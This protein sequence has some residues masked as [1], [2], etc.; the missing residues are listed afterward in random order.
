MTRVVA[1]SRL[2]F[3]LLGLPAES[4][5]RWPGVDGAPGLPIRHFGGVGLMVERPG[6]AVTVEGAPAWSAS[7]PLAPRALEFARQAVESLPA[8]ERRPFHISM[9]TAPEEHT[10]LGV[11]TQLGLAV[12]KAIAVECGHADWPAAELAVRI[13]RGER[14]AIGVHGFERGGLI[15][16]GGKL[17]G[18]TISP[19]VGRYDL[20]ASWSVLVFTPDAASEWHG[21]RE[22][23]AFARL[24]HLGPAPGETDALCR[25][26]L[27]GMLPALASADSQGFGEAV[28]EFNARVG[29]AFA[30]A[31]GG[32]YASPAVAA[33]VARLRALG[34]TGV[35]QSSWGPTVFAL[36]RREEA[37]AILKHVSDVPA[38]LAGVSAGA[39]V[40]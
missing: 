37:E 32:R 21:G 11:G 17:P 10:G 31:Q 33:C 18:E 35:G 15:V 14:S 9:E 39:T 20:P 6:L 25:L 1:P 8:R 7:G 38:V 16:E 19:L 5:E 22:R 28:Y 30:P 40:S 12:A 34:V 3:G 24:G 13:G 29:D 2:H 26:V 23:L 27:T 4:R 36:I